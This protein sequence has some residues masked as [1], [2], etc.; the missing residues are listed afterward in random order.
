M[1]DDVCAVAD[2]P[3]DCF[4]IAPAFMADHD[5]EC[6][7]TSLKNAP[8]GAG[9]IDAFFGGIELNFVLETCD[10]SVPIDDQC[11]G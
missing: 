8:P 7:R 9:R 10:A 4:R 6:Q 11:S 2:G 1:E 5:T 3:T